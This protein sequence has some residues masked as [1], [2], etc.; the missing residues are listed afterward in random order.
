MNRPGR[1]R[2][3]D[4]YKWKI[5]RKNTIFPQKPDLGYIRSRTPDVYYI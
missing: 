1:S 2:L 3:D 4:R 5:R